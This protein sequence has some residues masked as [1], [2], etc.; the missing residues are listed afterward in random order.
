VPP[1]A[2]ENSPSA[3]EINT[4][5]NFSDWVNSLGPALNGHFNNLGTQI[6][7]ATAGLNQFLQVAQI[8][9]NDIAGIAGAIASVGGG[10][11]SRLGTYG[12]G[13]V[14]RALGVL[15]AYYGAAPTAIPYLP[16]CA[17]NPL[18]SDVCAV[19][20]F[21]ENTFLAGPVGRLLVPLLVIMLDLAIVFYFV[22]QVRNWLRK[23][24]GVT[25]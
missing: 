12:M 17:T 5:Y 23:A 25:G 15:G 14:N 8:F 6:G 20:W 10:L 24:E 9:F 2:T 19:W 4:T 13:M 7:N 22:R 1:L 11:L 3:W 21:L 16:S 18:A